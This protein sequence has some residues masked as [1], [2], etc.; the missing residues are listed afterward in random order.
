MHLHGENDL[1]ENKFSISEYTKHNLRMRCF[2]YL[3]VTGKFS[4]YRVRQKL[5]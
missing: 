3:F 4:R 2:F 5:K 1:V